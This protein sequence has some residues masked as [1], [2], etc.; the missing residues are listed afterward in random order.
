[1]KRAGVKLDLENDSAKIFGKEVALNL[2]LSGHYCIPI[3]RAE[4]I[5]V[6]EVFSINFEGMGREDRYKILI[7]LHRHFAHP[8]LKKLKS[9]PQ[10]ADLWKDDYTDMLE[11]IVRK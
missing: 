2:T 5:P 3:D 7:K 8:P 4:Q 1:M 11:D 6:E 10:D 9:L